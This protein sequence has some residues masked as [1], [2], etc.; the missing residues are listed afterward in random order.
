[1]KNYI[2]L[3]NRI[4]N[5]GELRQDR[6]GVGA[7]S[8]FGGR[9]EFNLRDRFPLVT[10]KE[11][12]FRVAF[13][14]MLWFLR[15]ERNTDYLHEHDCKL[16]DAWADEYGRVGRIYGF[17]WRNWGGEGIDQIKALIEG[18]KTNPHGRRHIVTAWN[19]ADLPYMSLPPC[20]W[21]FQCYVSNTGMLDMQVN[22]RS[23]DVALGAPFNIAQYALL[24]HLLARATGLLPRRLAFSFGDAHIYT[25]HV[26]VMRRV[27]EDGP[28]YGDAATLA[29]Y[30]DNIDI[31]GYKPS[32][33]NILGYQ[34]KAFVRM[35][36]AV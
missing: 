23:W 33:F 18:I 20:H 9:L 10:A 32:D 17:Q 7:L 21:S 31:D 3:V 34:P 27:A 29:I 6:T 24:L 11:T 25:N 28:V 22:Q 36:V 13:L 8:V 1:M 5:E 26:D 12:R 2:D 4:L 30:T 35:E 14:E 15:G 19:V 16:W